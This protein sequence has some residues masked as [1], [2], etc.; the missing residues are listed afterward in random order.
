MARRANKLDYMR[1]GQW[2]RIRW[3]DQGV[4]CCD[5]GLVHTHQY[6]VV[7]GRIFMRCWRDPEGTA[8]GRKR[9]RFAYRPVK[10][11]RSR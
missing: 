5:C 8:E 7:G 1:P 6:K 2:R 11:R 3:R 10:K 9:H 4:G